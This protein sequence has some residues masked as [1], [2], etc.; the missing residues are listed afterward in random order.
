MYED[1][2]GLPVNLFAA[3]TGLRQK[4]QPN[5]QRPER[6]QTYADLLPGCYDPKERAEDFLS[7]GVVASV[8][9]PSLPRFGGT[10]FV[11]FK[12]KALADLCVKA[13]NDFVFDEWCAG[14]PPGMFVPMTICQLWD[15]K[16]AALEIERCAERGARAIS[17]PENVVSFGLPS[18]YTDHWDPVWSVCQE[19]DLALCMHLATAGSIEQYRP[20][21]EAPHACLIAA[22]AA[23]MSVAALMN[24]IFSPV[25]SKF[26]GL[27]FV[28]S[29]SGIGWLPSALERA[30][31]A[32]ERKQGI[33]ELNRERPSEIWERNLFVCQVE[34]NLGLQFIDHIGVDK[35]LW[36]LDY[37]HPDTVFPFAQK[38]AESIFAEAKL[39]DDDIAAITHRNS[40]KIFRWTPAELPNK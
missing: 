27:R 33:E 17:I 11:D 22:A 5:E 32:W 26:P 36:E 3:G 29:E 15:A 35:I 12:D 1:Q 30:D 7:N 2:I 9:F 24:L 31:L 38:H 20:S 14:G 21:P 10:L 40:E 34:E 28:F 6:P 39:S 37:P 13:Y 16:A 25:C 8:S 23:E 4:S 18:Y 19:A